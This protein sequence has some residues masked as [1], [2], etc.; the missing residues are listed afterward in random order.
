MLGYIVQLA[1]HAL[2]YINFAESLGIFRE[3][4]ESS[5]KL[6]YVILKSRKGL[7][8]LSGPSI[9]DQFLCPLVCSV[10]YLIFLTE[11]LSFPM[12][13]LYVVFAKHSH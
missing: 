2:T 10:F 5:Q 4:H 6:S 12:I 13:P 9:E 1:I 3:Y 7:A 11:P 8:I